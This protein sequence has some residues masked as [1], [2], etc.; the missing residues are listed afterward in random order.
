MVRPVAESDSARWPGWTRR[1]VWSIVAILFVGLA[2]FSAVYWKNWL[3]YSDALDQLNARIERLDGLLRAGNTIDSRLE[4][5]R[6]E[7]RPWLQPGGEAAQT[8]LSQRLRE[9]VVSN[10]GT[11]VSAQAVMA[12]AEEGKIPYLKLS[13]TISGEWES[14][15][16]ILAAV[17]AQQPSFWVRSSNLSREGRANLDTAHKSRLALQIDVPVAT[18]TVSAP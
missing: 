2:L 6:R 11:L 15:M 7:V 14:L 17:Q 1:A 16:R 5:A 18:D 13:V 3:R 10:E 12:P 9:L 8:R 4:M